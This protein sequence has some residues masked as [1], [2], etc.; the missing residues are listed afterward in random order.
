MNLI[1]HNRTIKLLE[2][3]HKKFSILKINKNVNNINFAMKK[4]KNIQLI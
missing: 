4:N 2:H 3:F 1:K